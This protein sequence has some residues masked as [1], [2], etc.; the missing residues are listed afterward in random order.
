MFLFILSAYPDPNVDPAPVDEPPNVKFPEP[1]AAFPNEN[2][3]G[4]ELPL[5]KSL[6]SEEADFFSCPKVN[7]TD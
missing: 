5:E 7:G 1:V 6:F 2:T 3:P 4:I